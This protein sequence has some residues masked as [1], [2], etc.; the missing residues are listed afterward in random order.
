MIKSGYFGDIAIFKLDRL[1]ENAGYENS[2]VLSEDMAQ[3]LVNPK[4]SIKNGKPT[5]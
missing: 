3:D 1:K 5:G 4:F 2:F